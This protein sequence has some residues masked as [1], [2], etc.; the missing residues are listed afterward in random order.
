MY[1]WEKGG[2][3]WI[4]ENGVRLPNPLIDIS[5]EVGNWR[6][7]GLLGFALDPNFLSNGRIYLLYIVD[8]HHLLHFGTPTYNPNTNEYFNAT[9]GRITRY[10]AQAATNFT[11][12]NPN[13]RTVLMGDAVNNGFPNLHQ[14]HGT[15]SLAFGTDGTLLAS[16]GDGASYS[17]VDQGSASETYYAQALADGIITSAE[18]VGAYR[19]Q[20]LSSYN[21]KIIRIDPETGAG[22][23]SNPFYQ[24]NNPNSVQSKV[25]ALGLRNP[26]R[27]IKKPNTGSHNPAD[28]DPGVFFIGDVGW[29]NREEFNVSDAPGLNF[30]WPKY[31]GMTHQP[32]YN[33]PSFTPSSHELAKADWRTGAPRA[34][35]NG[36]IV[37]IGSGQV[38]GP[39]FGGNCSIG[40]VW[41][42]GTDFPPEYQNTY[43]HADYGGDWIKNFVLNDNNELVQIRN[44]KAETNSIVFVSTDPTT[45]GLYYI[46]GAQGNSN[47]TANAVRRI[48]YTGN[49]VFPVAKAEA[50]ILYGSS[51]LTVDFSAAKSYDPDGANISFFWDFGDGT[52]SQ[53]ANPTHTFTGTGITSFQV[54]LTVTNELN[55]TDQASLSISLNNTPPNI[56]STSIDNTHT[57]PFNM[58]TNLNLSANVVD[59]EHSSNQLTYSWVTALYHNDHSHPEPVDNNP[60]TTSLLTP[61]GCDGATY[62]YRV[63][64]TVTDAGGLSSSYFKDIYPNC[65]GLSQTISFGQISDKLTTDTPFN[66]NATT[67]SGLSPIYFVSSGPATINGN[68]L[69]LTGQAGT[70]N[71]VITQP[72]NLTYAPAQALERSFEVSHPSAGGT[73]LTASYYDNINFTNLALERTDPVIDFDWGSF[74]PDPSMDVN[75]FSIV[76]EGEVEPIYS[77]NYTFITTTD[78]GL[79]LWV[80]GQQIIDQWIEQSATPHAGS[81]NLTAG[82]RVAIRMEYYENEG[83]A[84]AIL[85]WQSASQNREVIPQTHLFPLSNEGDTTPPDVNLST[86]STSVNGPFTVNVSFTEDI[87]GLSLADFSL[88]NGISSNL[89]GSG[90]NYSFTVTPELAG[91]LSIVLPANRVMD[92]AGNNNTASNT[93]ALTYSPIDNIP[94]DVTLSTASSTVNGAFTVNA[95]FTE[96]VTGLMLN[97][98][99]INNGTSSALSGSGANYNFTVTPINQGV[100]SISLPANRTMDAAGN[101]N[102]ASNT[103]NVTFSTGSG[104]DCTN[105]TNIALN[106][107]AT[108][109]SE[110]PSTPGPAERAVDGNTSGNWW[111]DFSITSTAWGSESWWEVDLGAIGTIETINVWNRND[112]CQS[113]LSDFYV[114]VSDVPFS[115]TNLNSTINQAGV[116]NYYTPNQAA[117]PTNVA[118]NR[119]GRYIRLQKNGSGFMVLAEVEVMGCFDSGPDVTPPDATLST[120]SSTV[121]GSFLVTA[122]FTENVTG[123]TSGDFSISNG[124]ISNLSGSGNQYTFTIVPI[125]EGNVAILLPSNR[126]TDA[127]GNGNTASNTLSVTYNISDV[128]PPDVTLS[129]ASSTVNEAF[130]VN[131]TFTESIT[132]LTL[133]DF[134]ITNGTSSALSGSGANYSF[135][136]TP[137]NQGVVSISLPANRATDAAGNGNNASN[138]LN[139]T[140]STGGGGD[141][142][143]VTNIALNKTATQSS[144]HPSTPGPAERAVDGNTSGNWWVDFSITSTAWGSESWWE[145]D[146]GAIGTIETIN[147]W[148]RNDCCQSFLSN[149]YVLVSDVPFSS[150]NLNSTINQAGVFSHQE[151][152]QAQ[153]PT[154]ISINRTGRYIRVQKNGSGFMA[155]AEVEVMGC[156]DS[157]PDITPPGVNLSTANTTVNGTFIV[158]ANFTEAISGLSLGDFDLS[159]GT[160]NNLSG[161]GANYSF[162]VT[163]TTEGTIS[164][165]LPANRVTDAAGNGN[166]ASNNLNVTYTTGGGDNTPPEITLSTTSNTTNGP[167]SVSAVF[168]EAITGL[169]LND[170]IINNGTASGLSGS[171]A[172]YS[173]TVNPTAEGLVTIQ[174]PANRVTDAAGNGNNPSNILSVTFSTNGG[175]NPPTGYCNSQGNAPWLEWISN[176]TFGSINNDSGKDLYGNY[177]NLS[178][179]VIKGMSYELSVTPRFSWTQFNEYIR[180]WIDFNR[181]GDF[182]DAGEQV[183]SGISPG[184][185]PQSPPT[186]VNGLISIPTTAS[187]G[188]TRMRVSMQRDAYVGPCEA[189][190]TGEVE[191][192]LVNI[193]GIFTP[194]SSDFNRSKNDEKTTLLFPNPVDMELFVHLKKYVDLSCT[195]LLYN[196]DGKLLLTQHIG[197]VPD[198][199]MLLDM[200]GYGSGIYFLKTKAKGFEEESHRIV[201]SR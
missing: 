82:Q 168:S 138:T 56:I 90:S 112:C 81:I 158:N 39:N 184:G 171:S 124:N 60:S 80:N 92:L 174:L 40:G 37:N 191:D 65:E 104:G 68:T 118:V 36:Q 33:N 163:P 3:V 166:I 120:A 115:S 140:F 69:T 198:D 46:G 97:D 10:E 153:R 147:V 63:F 192:Y 86:A 151:V 43:F 109:S 201:I 148:N 16:L 157:G 85:E 119:T 110:H 133:N 114:L 121:N 196:S 20:M 129:T 55:Q 178:A 25:W 105:V 173:F 146:L 31:E 19:S 70:V 130:T 6:D 128:T 164:I 59:A 143:N 38:P 159:N 108:Q 71:I 21:G 199:P 87:T 66:L 32:G 144:E 30:G 41:Y 13:S 15:G 187:D 152:G 149:F 111:V 155:L 160:A 4:V 100:V 186:V 58:G 53:L 52:T 188:P 170:F 177:T 91:N 200:S 64:L 17:S 181:D 73:G 89:S 61:I 137:I 142:N 183:L 107:T 154:A 101:G 182:E 26:C 169:A 195:I 167:F 98:F 139:V 76:W 23:S 126:V 11:T 72:G 88:T 127:A 190:S 84:S 24:S 45:G 117:R 93:L 57:F 12:V 172:N 194:P 162:T 44:F 51:P 113:F 8:R 29:S 96:N 131:A 123:L 179:T 135:T 50:N 165:S 7:F 47:N 99:S 94:P 150:T 95:I 103:L 2:K 156:F 22:I 116:A 197:K 189:F 28:G 18:N 102:N 193:S 134:N 48:F 42:D 67:S 106:K 83:G 79:R 9:I 175:G 14:S 5:E 49:I 1:V 132:G 136:V 122:D 54:T 74:S 176:V 77:Q 145:V 78:D 75:T 141:C 27:M 35:K 34:Y 161:S 125:A 180:V 185:S 62:W